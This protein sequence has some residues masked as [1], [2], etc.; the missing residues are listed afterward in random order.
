MPY[1]VL[2][3]LSLVPCVAA[4]LIGRANAP[5]RLVERHHSHH[6]TRRISSARWW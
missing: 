6:D 2:L 4:A 5:I 3:V 1:P